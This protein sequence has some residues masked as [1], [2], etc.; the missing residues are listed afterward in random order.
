MA[1]K[2]SAFASGSAD[3]D[4]LAT[5]V[6]LGR[7]GYL[8]LAAHQLASFKFFTLII[9]KGETVETVKAVE[10]RIANGAYHGGVE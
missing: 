7:S 8:L 5:N 10:V 3:R 2:E 9:G 4:T 1:A 6:W